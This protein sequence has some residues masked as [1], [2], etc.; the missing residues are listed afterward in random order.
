MIIESKSQFYYYKYYW[1]Y[2]F[3]VLSSE[4]SAL[5]VLDENKITKKKK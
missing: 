1:S 5:Q 4:I 2:R 3:T